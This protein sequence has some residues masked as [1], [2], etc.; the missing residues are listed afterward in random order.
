MWRVLLASGWAGA[1]ADLLLGTRRRERAEKCGGRCLA[2]RL[3][4]RLGRSRLRLVPGVELA[5]TL[6]LSGR[7]RPLEHRAGGWDRL[8]WR[9]RDEGCTRALVW[10]AG[11]HLFV[12]E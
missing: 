6:L 2:V 4:S 12:L 3:V 11:L 7:A 9:G 8:P 10:E 1:R 5:S